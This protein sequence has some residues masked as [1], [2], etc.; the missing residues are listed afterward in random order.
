MELVVDTNILFSYFWKNSFTRKVI[1]NQNLI[2]FA[3]EFTLVEIS[4]Y[5][6]EIMQKLKITKDEFNTAKL[7]IALSVD[8]IPVKKYSKKLPDAIKFSPDPNDIDFFALCLK[9]NLPLWS[10][11]KILKN[12]STVPVF[13]TEDLFDR[14]Y[15]FLF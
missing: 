5:K 10:N 14:F 4:K 1:T 6:K 2:L 13:S 8:F 11:D 12:Q 3:P 15:D 9:F 7:D